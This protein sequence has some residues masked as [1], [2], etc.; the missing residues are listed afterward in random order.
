MKQVE[1]KVIYNGFVKCLTT[2][3]MSYADAKRYSAD[4][5]T[6]LRCQQPCQMKWWY[7]GWGK[8]ITS[9]HFYNN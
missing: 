8:E 7:F 2:L 3:T 9:D 6:Y 4:N 1:E 5:G